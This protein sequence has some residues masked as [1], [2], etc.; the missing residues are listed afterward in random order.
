MWS[1]EGVFFI[2]FLLGVNGPGP[3]QV[4]HGPVDLSQGPGS[5]WASKKKPE[6][7]ASVPSHVGE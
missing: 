2:F 6:K 1:M 7:P 3:G 5:V 4:Q